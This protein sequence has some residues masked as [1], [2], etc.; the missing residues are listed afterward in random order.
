M[1]VLAVS[2]A[3]AV[4]MN[5]WLYVHL[6]RPGELEVELAVP[7]HW[8]SDLR[9]DIPF[10]RL[11]ELECRVHPLVPTASGEDYR[12][13]LAWYQ[14]AERV[15]RQ[16]RPDLIYLDEEPYSVAAFQF[17]MLARRTGTPCVF[18]SMQNLVRRL[19]PPF[20]LMERAVYRAAVG[21]TAL[22]EEVAYVLRRRGFKKPVHIVPLAAELSAF[23]PDPAPELRPCRDVT[24]PVIGYV[25]RLAPSKGVD[26]F[27]TSL[28]A[29]AAEG[30]PCA[31]LIVGGGPATDELG[32]LA[33]ALGL[34]GRV[35]FVPG[36]AHEEVA[37]YYNALDVLVLP[38]RTTPT[39]KEQFGRVLVEALACGVP[40]VGS[41]SG[42][43]PEVIGTTRGGLIFPEKD[44]RRLTDCLR[45]LI[46]DAPFRHRLADTGRAAVGRLYSYEAVAASLRK[47]LLAFG[48]RKTPAAIA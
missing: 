12:M 22:T 26:L 9:G 7:T 1:R 48:E 3:A 32:A 4:A 18:H 15:L 30:R 40:V 27:L 44:P 5:Q 38:S 11:P 35:R 10:S 31:G 23:R 45:L 33:A 42:A 20:S 6:P 37:R 39:W 24:V 43:I 36:V 46:A 28:A 21:A 34:E 14:G 17:T 41:D 25:G 13:H 16:V 8:G 29:L 2:H 47:A 19:P